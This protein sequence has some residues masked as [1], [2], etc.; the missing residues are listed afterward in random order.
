MPPRKIL[1]S[2]G[3]LGFTQKLLRCH[4]SEVGDFVL[5]KERAGGKKVRVVRVPV[6]L[7]F[8]KRNA[9]KI[10]HLDVQFPH[11][12]LDLSA[13]R[14]LSI[15]SECRTS[16]RGLQISSDSEIVFVRTLEFNLNITRLR[17]ILHEWMEFCG[18]AKN[19]DG[20]KCRMKQNITRFMDIQLE[21]NWDQE[22]L[23]MQ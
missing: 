11:F 1:I 19:L 21:E 2:S 17:A 10:S 22:Q 13:C 15:E 7:L 9:P 6:R 18:T 20:A 12:L 4:L 8:P 3:S 16:R 14:R 5:R 23:H